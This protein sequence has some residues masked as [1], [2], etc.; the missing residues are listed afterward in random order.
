M[1]WSTLSLR[2]I[3]QGA[4]QTLRRF[5]FT[6]LSAILGT[7]T[8]I[9]LADL[10]YE[11][12]QSYEHLNRIVASSALG[13]ILFFNLQLFNE[14]YFH[15]IIYKIGS[16]LVGVILVTTCY[17]LLPDKILT[18]HW[19][20]FFLIVASLH[21][22]AAYVPYL[23]KRIEN[24]FWQY[25][26]ILFLRFLTAALYTAVLYLGIVLAIA[27]I[28]EL[29]EVDID[30]EIYVQCWFFMVGIFNTWFFLAG[31]PADFVLLESDTTYPKG[32]KIFTQY[33]LLPLVTLYLAI[34][35]A[36]MAKIIFLW[37]WPR[38]WVS[39]LV[40]GFSVA[41]IFSLLLIY[42]IRNQTGNSWIQ[43]YARWF[44]RALFPLI[45]LLALAIWRRVNQYGITES[46]Y[47]VVLLAGWLLLV[48]VYFLGSKIK[49]IKFIPVTLSVLALLA[50]WGPWGMLEV[51]E[52]SQTH[53]LAGLFQK[54][55]ILKNGKVYPVSRPVSHPD[56][57][58]ISSILTYLG[59]RHQYESIK[60]WFGT[61]IDS[62]LALKKKENYY[63]NQAPEVM[64]LLGLEYQWHENKGELEPLRYHL[65]QQELLPVK[66]FDYMFSYSPSYNRN[67]KTDTTVFTHKNWQLQLLT[68]PDNNQLRVQ[69]NKQEQIMYLSDLLKKLAPEKEQ[70]LPV[71][72]LT[73]NLNFTTGTVQ[74]IFQSLEGE[75]QK[76]KY[77]LNSFNATVLVQVR[78]E[79]E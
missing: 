19:L 50:A 21:L 65:K 73:Y 38:G 42:P 18:R 56:L 37:D 57:Y 10:P 24:G 9:Y 3:V 71:N 15:R 35:Y 54:Y 76:G 75:Q 23:N 78:E 12:Q 28:R 11:Q 46:R 25:N 36:Y 34:L 77:Q 64:E 7:G 52:R 58:Q 51:S 74:F 69:L 63:I 41:G 26:K 48:A 61:R 39:N 8:L 30:T 66:N 68:N 32:L 62:I 43:T 14:R 17:F 1:Q 49:N 33:V 2:P 47:A 29:F 53:R 59:E 44:Y 45:I 67:Q 16:I 5:P 20:R 6:L 55:G 40:L 13:L 27:A 22:L 60:P 70:S 4:L 31:V 79:I 72:K